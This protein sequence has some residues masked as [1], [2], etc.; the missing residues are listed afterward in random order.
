MDLEKNLFNITTKFKQL[1]AILAKEGLCI[2]EINTSIHSS[3][4]NGVLVNITDEH[5]KILTGHLVVGLK[6]K[7]GDSY[8]D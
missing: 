2:K 4:R 1:T 8:I 6:R 7:D 3:K 5:G